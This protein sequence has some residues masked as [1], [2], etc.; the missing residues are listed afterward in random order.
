MSEDSILD[1]FIEDSDLDE[2]AFQLLQEKLGSVLR[3]PPA[4]PGDEEG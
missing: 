2:E 4:R 3:L 1:P